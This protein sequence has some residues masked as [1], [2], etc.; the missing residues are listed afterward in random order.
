[1]REEAHSRI[2][3][4]FLLSMCF[5]NILVFRHLEELL[6]QISWS[7]IFMFSLQ[8]TSVIALFTHHCILLEDVFF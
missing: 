1:M 5:K 3:T 7:V 4:S 8:S 6:L 2:K